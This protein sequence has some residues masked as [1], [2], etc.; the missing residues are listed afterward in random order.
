VRRWG[1]YSLRNASRVL[2]VGD[3]VFVDVISV[4]KNSMQGKLIREARITTVVSQATAHLE[5]TS[6]DEDHVLGDGEA[7]HDQ[8]I[9]DLI[10]IRFGL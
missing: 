10:Y 5:V 4:K 7:V 3:F 6:R 8:W 1:A 2:R 9:V